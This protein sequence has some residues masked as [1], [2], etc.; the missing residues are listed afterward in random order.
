MN[1][2]ELLETLRAR[3]AR[4]EADAERCRQMII[5]AEGALAPTGRKAAP[6]SAKP[7]RGGE[8]RNPRPTAAPAGGKRAAHRAAMQ[9]K[10]AELLAKQPDISTIA[11]SQKL[12]I[13]WSLAKELLDQVRGA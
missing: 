1:D 5:L 9:A 3:L 12:S 4:A 11:A 6:K 2:E 13:G 7:R 10:L 8:P